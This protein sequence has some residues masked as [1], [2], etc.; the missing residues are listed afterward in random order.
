MIFGAT[1]HILPFAFALDNSLLLMGSFTSTIWALVT[2][3]SG[4]VF[5]AWGIAG[6]FKNYHDAV[7]RLLVLSA[8]L[9]LI[10]SGYWNWNAAIGLVMA[11]IGAAVF[12]IGKRSGVL[13][14]G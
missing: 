4:I 11:L 2:A 9:L 3:V 1:A 7:A 8:G 12:M 5:L 6:P 14:Q 10:F 13:C